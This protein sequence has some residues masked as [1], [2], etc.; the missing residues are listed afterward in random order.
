MNNHIT[1]DNMVPPFHDVPLMELA[2]N[3]KF[4]AIITQY[5]IIIVL[6]GS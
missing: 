2:K 1:P 4:S 6:N 3:S 5:A